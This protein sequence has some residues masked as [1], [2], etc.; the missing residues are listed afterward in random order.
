MYAVSVYYPREI[1]TVLREAAAEFRVVVLTGARQTGKSTLLER[2]F[3]KS[4]RYV[5]LDDSRALRLAQDDPELFLEQYPPPLILDEIQYAPGLLSAVKLRVDRV[6]KKGQF[7]ITGSQQFTMMRRLQETLAGRAALFQLLP[8]SLAEGPAASRTYRYRALVG[9]YPELV[10]PGR[11]HPERWYASYLATYIERDVQPHY[12]IEKIAHFRDLVFLLATR[13]S[14]LLNYS[15][16]S[17]DLGVSMPA[18]KSWVRILEASQIIYLLRPY[19]VNLGSR[20][21]K[22]PKVYF[23]DTGFLN[24]LLGNREENVLTHGAQ[25][26]ALFEN[27][28]VQETLKRYLNRGKTPPLFYYR[29]NNGLEVDLIVEEKAGVIRPCEIKRTR[30]PHPGMLQ[31]I[32]RLRSLNRKSVLIKDGSLITLS[33]GKSLLRRDAAAYGLKEFLATL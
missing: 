16:L 7:L 9:A 3:K 25:A 19:Y 22:S 6:Q 23:C 30:T 27:F 33:E 5:S 17:G 4:H 14:Q 32:E 18:V 1:E 31:P 8:M 13:C 10:V 2:L 24:Y 11:H 26:G 12:Q 21:V 15:A 28:V 20:I 29:T